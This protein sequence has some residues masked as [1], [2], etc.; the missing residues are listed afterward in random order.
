MKEQLTLMA[1]HAHPDDEAI[2]TGGVLARYA[3]EGI[4]TV[5]V[6]CT[7]G[8]L[9]DAPGGVT[10]DRDAHDAELV[11]QTRLAELRQSCV[12]LGITHLELLGYHDS[13]MMGW[14]QN[15]APD[16]F[17]K[18]PVRDAAGRLAALMERYSPQVVVTYDENGFYGHPDHIKANRITLESARDTGIP[19]KLY[20]TAVS[21]QR[22]GELA[23]RFRDMQPDS[24][25]FDFD[26]DD[27]P[28]GVDESA[29]TTMVDVS[30]YTDRKLSS[31]R[32]HAS[33]GENMPFLRL[34]REVFNEAFGRESFT[35]VEDATG[36]PIPEDDLF[37]GLR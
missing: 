8:E 33:Q 31:M 37:A 3:S 35:R 9:G 34:P 7:N 23:R 11:V 16:S 32:A 29:I 36:A 28:F 10:P 30:A 17:W 19:R 1:V 15:E 6:T 5:L 4:R 2:S 27:P 26:P 24:D 14:K 13:G 22:I 25:N 20:Y 12:E 18:T 21:K